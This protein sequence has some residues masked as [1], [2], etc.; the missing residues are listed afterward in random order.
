MAMQCQCAQQE[1]YLDCLLKTPAPLVKA[2]TD[3][4]AI[5]RNQWCAGK[6]VWEAKPGQHHHG[7][8][9]ALVA[10]MW[11]PSDAGTAAGGGGGG[12][13]MLVSGGRD[14]LIHFWAADRGALVQTIDTTQ[15]T[16]GECAAWCH[17]LATMLGDVIGTRV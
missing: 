5:R 2:L 9:T 3:V 10:G 16:R 14:G 11:R 6:L 7:A 15:Y 1:Q 12:G 8:V 17:L 4:Q 13:P